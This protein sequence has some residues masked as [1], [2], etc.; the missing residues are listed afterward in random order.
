M[1][2]RQMVVL[3]ISVLLLSAAAVIQGAEADDLFMAIAVPVVLIGGTLI[4]HFREKKQ[5]EPR[6]P[7]RKLLTAVVGMLLVQTLLIF[8]QARELGRAN[9]KL[10]RAASY[11]DST[12]LP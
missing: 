1:N 12:R 6:S 11:L 9:A 7:T 8:A 10:Q 2:K 5:A 3:W 4:Y